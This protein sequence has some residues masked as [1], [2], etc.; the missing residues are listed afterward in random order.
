MLAAG[1]APA[2][3]PTSV[4]LPRMVAPPGSRSPARPRGARAGSTC[5]SHRARPQLLFSLGVSLIL[6]YG[7]L[8]LSLQSSPGSGVGLGLLAVPGRRDHGR[9]SSGAAAALAFEIPFEQGFLIGAVVA[10]D[11]PRDPDPALR[12]PAR[13][14]EGRP[15]RGR[16]VGAQRPDRRSAGPHDRRVHPRGRGVGGGRRRRVLSPTSGSRSCSE[17]RSGSCSR[18][19]SRS[20]ASASG[21]SLPALVVGLAVAAGYVSIDAAG[22]SGYLGAFIAGLI[23]GNSERFGLSGPRS[24]PPRDRVLRRLRHARRRA[25]RLPR[26]RREPPARDDRRRGCFRRSPSSPSSSSSRGP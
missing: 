6:F 1:L 26:A 21:A 15:D 20:A 2:C 19:S 12:A 9:S 14:A 13:P 10:P 11:R 16:R 4:R 8:E 7:G 5:R 23:V 24:G 25:A 18:S 3:S 22:G 17:P